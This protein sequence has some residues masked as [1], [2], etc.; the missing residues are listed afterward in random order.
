MDDCKEPEFG[1]EESGPGVQP[2]A[3]YPRARNLIVIK[4][5]SSYNGAVQGLAVPVCSPVTKS[6]S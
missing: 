6:F 2:P 4:V 5:V 1:L 3:A